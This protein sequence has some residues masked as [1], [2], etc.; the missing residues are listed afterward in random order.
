MLKLL[1][2]S[3]RILRILDSR[4]LLVCTDLHGNLEDFRQIVKC[5][6]ELQTKEP[7]AFLLFSGDLIHGPSPTDEAQWPAS[8]GEFYIDKSVQVVEEFMELQEK[9]PGQVACLLGNHEH[10]HIGGPHTPKFWDDETSHFEKQAG[11]DKVDIFKK[12]FCSF[13]LVATTSCGV[14]ICH[15]APNVEIENAAQIET[16]EYAGYENCS[17]SMVYSASVLLCL[18]WSR[19]CPSKVARKFLDILSQGRDGLDIAVFGHDIV[20]EGFIRIG[21]EQLQL[22]TSFAVEKNKKH[23][24]E[25]DLA[26]RYRSAS[27]FREGIE[28]RKLY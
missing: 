27:D 9:F 28:L 13:P 4:K 3:S 25:L 14:A 10:S 12:L 2:S 21:D 5:F 1:M 18:L 15:A 23:L 11:A 8:F 20:R 7:S 22:S 26:S 19:V 16:V 24:L 6:I 17:L